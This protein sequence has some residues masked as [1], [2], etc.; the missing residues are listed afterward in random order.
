QLPKNLKIMAPATV[1]FANGAG[2]GVMME[3]NM[4]NYSDMSLLAAGSG[5][6]AFFRSNRN[7]WD[8]TGEIISPWRVM[9]LAADL[10]GWSTA[11][12]SKIFARRRRRDN[13]WNAMEEMV[14]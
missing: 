11:T 6:R 14:K 3:A 12:S 9:I 1:K 13:A 2:Y 8:A 4:I 5:F 10:N 7:G